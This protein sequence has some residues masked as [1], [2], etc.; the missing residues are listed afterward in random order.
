MDI[1][2]NSMNFIFLVLNIHFYNKSSAKNRLFGLV[3][4]HGY[5][6]ASSIADSCNRLLG[7]PVLSAIDMPLDVTVDGI[8]ELV[9]KM[10]Q[11]K[12][13]YQ[14]MILL[15]DRGRWNSWRKTG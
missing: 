12:F 8:V 13:Y 9:K 11:K 7:H 10:M 6:T 15:V 4:A 3:V 5:S 2:L 14:E 1:E